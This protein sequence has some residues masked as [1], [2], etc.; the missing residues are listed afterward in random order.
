MSI[1][2]FTYKFWILLSFP[3]HLMSHYALN[4]TDATS[5]YLVYL[6]ETNHISI[7]STM[8]PN[9]LFWA[10]AINCDLSF[11]SILYHMILC[12]H[13]EY[14]DTVNIG[15]ILMNRLDDLKHGLWV[16]SVLVLRPFIDKMTW[17]TWNMDCEVSLQ[18]FYSL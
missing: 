8:T 1:V 4:P 14:I 3:I 2:D 11:Q 6:P 16:V 17:M 10:R 12:F 13:I 7:S 18:S 15:S 5:C 9:Y